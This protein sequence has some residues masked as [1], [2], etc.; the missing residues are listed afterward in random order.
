VNFTKNSLLCALLNE[1]RTAS[2]TIAPFQ[3]RKNIMIRKVELNN[4]IDTRE[5]KT[6]PTTRKMRLVKLDIIMKYKAGDI[7]LF[8]LFINLGSIL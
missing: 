5:S 3:I 6:T 8:W 7:V 1:N 2:P 4:F